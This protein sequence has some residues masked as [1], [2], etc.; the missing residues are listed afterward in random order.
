MRCNKFH[1]VPLNKVQNNRSIAGFGGG[2]VTVTVTGAYIA[3]YCITLFIPI[4]LVCTLP[5][6]EGLGMDNIQN[7]GGSL[8][9]EP[10]ADQAPETQNLTATAGPNDVNQGASNGINQNGHDSY[11]SDESLESL[12]SITSS[13]TERN[14]VLIEN[15][16]LALAD[17]NHTRRVN[18]G[19]YREAA[20]LL[21]ERASVLTNG[22]E[23]VENNFPNHIETYREVITSIT[24]IANT[25]NNSFLAT[26]N[27][28]P[29]I[30]SGVLFDDMQTP[31][32][33]TA[34]L[35]ERAMRDINSGFEFDSDTDSDAIVGA[36]Q[37]NTN[38]LRLN[39]FTH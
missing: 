6:I 24:N 3:A 2:T 27:A 28:N 4:L 35:I 21:A 19:L 8:A 39:T 32:D 30:D 9:S 16:R 37:R 33:D 38:R 1:N 34:D 10:V 36:F 13:Q 26:I 11:D 12:E 7:T 29:E 20:R 17:I 23:Y 5:L 18:M 14:R 25:A 31:L 15:Y 22:I